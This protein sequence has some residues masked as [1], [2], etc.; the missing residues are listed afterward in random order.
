V[1]RVL[2]LV[3]ILA[4]G[5]ML[6]NSVAQFTQGDSVTFMFSATGL[7]ASDFK[8]LSDPK[9]G[10]GP[11]YTAAHVQ[12]TGAGGTGSGWGAPGNPVPEPATMLLFGTGMIGLAGFGRK[13]LLKRS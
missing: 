13:K 1:K 7:D 5:L 2:L 8:F 9:G 11:F 10:A 6:Y 4:A 12:N 3:S